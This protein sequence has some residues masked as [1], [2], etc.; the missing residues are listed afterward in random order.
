LL[1]PAM[2]LVLCLS[3][4]LVAGVGQG[5][6][7]P[8]EDEA[9]YYYDEYDPD[10]EVPAGPNL[11]EL[12]SGVGAG[13]MSLVSNQELQARVGEAF[14]LGANLTGQAVHMAVPVATAA[15]QQVPQ[16]V[17]A[18][19]QVV[20]NVLENEI[21]QESVGRA[22]EVAG[23]VV[24]QAPRFV[25]GGTRL[26]GGL[27]KATNDTV[28]L[29]VQN[30]QELAQQIPL[31]TRFAQAYI[32]VNARN[33]QKL[34]DRFQTSLACELNCRD[35]LGAELVRCEAEHCVMPGEEEEEHVV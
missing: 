31:L 22:G 16:V 28:P 12:L 18:G 1:C 4:L 19:R 14:R 30:L 11:L 25:S 6:P 35:L 3:V 20:T 26:A 7:V 33:S 5:V 24:Q 17:S 13:V 8:Q 2:N 15:I 10:A 21:V 34:V 32:T 9:E 27:V 29:L 23:V